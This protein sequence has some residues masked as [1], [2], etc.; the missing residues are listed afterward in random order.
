MKKRQYDYATVWNQY[1]FEEEDCRFLTCAEEDLL[2]ICDC[3]DC[4]DPH[5]PKTSGGIPIHYQDGKLYVLKEGPHTR[6]CG[7]SGSKKSRTVCRGAVISAVKNGDSIILNDPKGEI[8]GDPKIQALLEEEGVD[9]H[10]LDFRNFDKD[11]YNCLAQTFE[12][13]QKSQYN[14]AYSSIDKY[15]SMLVKSKKGSDDP[16][17]NDTAG[18]LLNC[19]L[20]IMLHS[21]LQKTDGEKLFH[22]SSLKNF[23]RQDRDTIRNI[24]NSLILNSSGDLQCTALKN[25]AD[26]LENPERTYACIVQSANELL[27][28]FCSSDSLLQ[29]LS[30][31]TFD[32]RNFYRRPSALFM[33]VPDEHAAYDM[34]VGYLMDTFYQVLVEEYSQIYQNSTE[35]PCGIKFICDEAASVKIND[36]S[37]KISASRSRQID[38]TLIYQSDK[39]MQQAYP[40]DFTT[41]CGNAKHYI[42]LGSSD[43]DILQA[44]SAQTGTTSIAPGGRT[45]PLVTVEDLRRMR[46]ERTFKDA[47]LITGNHLYAAQLPDYDVYPFLHAKPFHTWPTRIQEIPLSTYTPELLLQDFKQG[48]ITFSNHVSPFSGSKKRLNNLW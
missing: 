7:E 26:I 33:V 2:K 37:S 41:I 12:F 34:V 21:L 42:F 4:S 31:S 43:Y 29:M 45:A 19:G 20:K 23:I 14:Q 35:A 6:V 13:A 27:S 36:M 24:I 8:S 25:Y 11:G 9:V 30:L 47:L 16:F 5:R 17:W 28:A 39:Q 40:N 48:K 18:S 3:M 10:I 44:V 1:A 38:W 32:I 22:L 15:I 46:K